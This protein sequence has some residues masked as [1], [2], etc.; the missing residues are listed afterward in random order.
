MVS[1]ISE[2]EAGAGLTEAPVEE[3]MVNLVVQVGYNPLFVNSMDRPKNKNE[4]LKTFS[5]AKEDVR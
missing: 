5:R 2:K 4:P 1:R 3:A